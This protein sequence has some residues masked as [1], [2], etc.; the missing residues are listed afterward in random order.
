MLVRL[1]PRLHLEDTPIDAFLQRI[2]SR[3]EPR[4]MRR[5]ELEVAV[6]IE[7]DFKQRLVVSAR[8]YPMHDAL[9]GSLFESRGQAT[10]L[11]TYP[12]LIEHCTIEHP[13]RQ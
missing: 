1:A 2:Y 5:R 8:R 13:P 7:S 3:E 12:L 10:H 11:A 6:K 9:A 4:G